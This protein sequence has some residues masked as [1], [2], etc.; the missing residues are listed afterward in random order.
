MCMT[1]SL[2]IP[3][4]IGK[5]LLH[6]TSTII[7]LKIKVKNNKTKLNFVKLRKVSILL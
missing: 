2:H 3:G 6:S 5:K 4:D 1:S 7:D